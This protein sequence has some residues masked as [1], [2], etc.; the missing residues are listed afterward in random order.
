MICDVIDTHQRGAWTSIH[1]RIKVLRDSGFIGLCNSNSGNS[2]LT[3]EA[4][5]SNSIFE[6]DGRT[7]LIMTINDWLGFVNSAT[8]LNVLDPLRPRV[9]KNRVSIETSRGI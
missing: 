7:E 9:L 1:S 8:T 4:C 3:A 5:H 2:F 6:S